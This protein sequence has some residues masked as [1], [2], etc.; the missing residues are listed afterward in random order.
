MFL[1]PPTVDILSSGIPSLKAS[2]LSCFWSFYESVSLSNSTEVRLVA[3]LAGHDVRS[4]TGSN[5]FGIRQMCQLDAMTPVSPA[6]VKQKL[7]AIRTPIPEHD[8]WRFS[9]L[10]NYLEKRYQLESDMLDTSE[11]DALIASIC[12]S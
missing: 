10:K 2:L 7:L 1:D 4:T 3:T 8:T 12:S 9:C 5:I 11:V 6:L